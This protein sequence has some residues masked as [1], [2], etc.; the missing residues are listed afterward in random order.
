LYTSDED[1]YDIISPLMTSLKI[2]IEE[3][4]LINIWDEDDV[5]MYGEVKKLYEFRNINNEE[6]GFVIRVDCSIGK[7]LGY[8]KIIYNKGKIHY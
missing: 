3:Y 7:V 8:Q 5:Y 2:N 4:K 6:E 1:V